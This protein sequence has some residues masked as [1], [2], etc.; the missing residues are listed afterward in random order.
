VLPAATALW[1]GPKK[2]K[3]ELFSA[4]TAGHDVAP[5]TSL[6]AVAASEA[7]PDALALW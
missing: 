5:T 2:S 4:S 3:V 7:L 1:K 6:E